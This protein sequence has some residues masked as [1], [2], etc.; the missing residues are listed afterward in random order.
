[1]SSSP[2][3]DPLVALWQSARKPDAHKLSADVQRA[4]RMHTTLYQTVFGVCVLVGV[5]L[6]FEEATQRIATH[7]VLT[8]VWAIAIAGGALWHRR[9]QAGLADVLTLDTRQMLTAM[10]ARTKRGLLLARC[11]YAGTPLGALAGFAIMRGADLAFGWQQASGASANLALVQTA[12]GVGVLLIMMVCG[13][14]LARIHH[15]QLQDLEQKLKAL[16][17]Y[18]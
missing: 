2:A 1:M 10:I 8:V 6:A 5:L 16:E 12:A 4:D 7:G 14:A 3:S 13:V 17:S 15:R 9:A 18:V 11:L